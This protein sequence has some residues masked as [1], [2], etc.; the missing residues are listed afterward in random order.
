MFA[1]RGLP[2]LYARAGKRGDSDLITSIKSAPTSTINPNTHSGKSRQVL[3]RCKS[4][5]DE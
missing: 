2:S 4:M 5:M 3:S 1:D